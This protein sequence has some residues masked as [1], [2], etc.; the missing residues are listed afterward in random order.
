MPHPSA[1]FT[2]GTQPNRATKV[3]KHVPRKLLGI[4]FLQSQIK[5][6]FQ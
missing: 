5:H 3:I 4:N 2:Y 1:R 6:K